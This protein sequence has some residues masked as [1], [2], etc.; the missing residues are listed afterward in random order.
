[1][2]PQSQDS[3]GVNAKCFSASLV[4]KTPLAVAKLCMQ[5]IKLCFILCAISL[6]ATAIETITFGVLGA[7]SNQRYAYDWLTRQ[8]E[9]SH[10]DI[11]IK[12]MALPDDKFKEM[13]PIWFAT[14]SG[15]DVLTWQG[16]ERL[17][18]LIGK[19]L[20]Q[21]LDD[22]WQEH[23]LHTQFD[24][25]TIASISADGHQYAI[26]LS[27][28]NWGFY[29]RKSLFDSLNIRPPQTWEQFLK[30]CTTLKKA[31]IVPITIGTKTNWT[32]AAWFSYITLRLYGF[33]YYSSLIR[34]EIPFTDKKVEMIFEM[35]KEL[36]DNKCFSDDHQQYE[37]NET[38]P[39]LY[40][41]MSGMTLIGSFF[42]ANIPEAL[43][44]DFAYFSFPLITADVPRYELA[45][46][47][48]LIIPA[49]SKKTE[50]TDTF[51]RFMSR[52]DVQSKLNQKLHTL[53][54]NIH[55]TVS[56]DKLSTLGLNSLLSSPGT[57][58]FFDRDTEAKTYSI[59]LPLFV[60]FMQEGDVKLTT[61]KLENMR[62]QGLFDSSDAADFE[63]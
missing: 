40:R 50:V 25:K 31:N 54:A 6:N 16:G 15:P 30:A 47:D 8:F 13:M 42:T 24:V 1:M 20:L 10:P 62:Q 35:W 59:V 61:L 38:M 3:K 55:A 26:P 9:K 11:K 36:L 39:S 49:F 22:F 12:T 63:K 4:A 43:I 32:A 2:R 33:E 44:E 53:P 21:D 60:D 48:V 34:G 14:K 51:L 45:P 37:W 18:H 56:N 58:Y 5:N 17:N 46:L 57:S 29:Y 7:D 27:Y 52:A 28:Y 23:Q 19:G 41:N